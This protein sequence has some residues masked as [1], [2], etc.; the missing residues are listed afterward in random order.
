MPARLLAGTLKRRNIN[1]PLRTRPR[2]T[3]Y[4]QQRKRLCERAS[5]A[6]DFSAAQPWQRTASPASAS[7]LTVL[8][9]ARLGATNAAIFS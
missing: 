7:L 9:S 2:A 5:C 8:P 4:F 3:V 1:A 6:A